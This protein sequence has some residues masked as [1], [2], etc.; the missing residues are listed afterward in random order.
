MSETNDLIQNREP[1]LQNLRERLN[2]ERA[3]VRT[4]PFQPVNDLPHETL[5]GL[6][7]EEL[8]EVAKKRVPFIN[9]EIVETTE[10]DLAETLKKLVAEYGGGEVMTSTDER[11]ADFGLAD[12]QGQDG[13]GY[14]MHQWKVGEEYREENIATA[15]GSNVAIAFAEFLLAE[16][17]SIVVESTPGQGRTL[18]FLPTHYLSIVPM[19]KI[20]ARTT[21]FADFYQEKLERGEKIGS[22]VNIISGPSNSGDIEMVLVTG[23]HGP[24]EV[25]Y[26]VV[27]DR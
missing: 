4:H 24:I 12:F 20:V 8:L 11:F 14:T 19:S 6:S 27:K 5:A 16:S 15:Q 9:A 1:F 2:I 10:A 22:D 25:K 21:Q 13:D 7:Q 18:H 26:V 3:D 17:G 23:L